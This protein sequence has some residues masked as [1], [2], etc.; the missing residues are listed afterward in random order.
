MYSSDLLDPQTTILSVD[1]VPIVDQT[2][3]DTQ[4]TKK[5]GQTYNI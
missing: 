4:P 5:L 3:T 2:I 1:E